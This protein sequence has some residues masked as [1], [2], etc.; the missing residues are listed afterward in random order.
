MEDCIFCKIATGEMPAKKLYD[1][2]EVFVIPDLR[3]MAPSHLLVIPYK[4]IET[5]MDVSREDL[6]LVGK[7]YGVIQEMAKKIGVDQ[8]GF[9]VLHNVR[10]W[11]HQRVFHIHFHLLAGK[12]FLDH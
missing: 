6:P 2:G 8:E 12:K 9:R 4:H 11:G 1:D 10:E 7:I 3:P 5:L